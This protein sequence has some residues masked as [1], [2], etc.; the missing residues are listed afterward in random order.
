MFTNGVTKVVAF[1]DIL[2]HRPPTLQ[3]AVDQSSR[4]GDA[5]DTI[6]TTGGGALLGIRT[7]HDGV[8]ISKPNALE[9]LA[10]SRGDVL[11]KALTVLSRRDPGLVDSNGARREV[12][13]NSDD[14]IIAVA[15]NRH[16]V[17]VLS[18]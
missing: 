4:A 1:D 10:C 2:K 11:V 5:V 7:V 13:R 18:V 12:S 15:V 9:R 16:T 8:E 6:G 14:S 17:N 3:T